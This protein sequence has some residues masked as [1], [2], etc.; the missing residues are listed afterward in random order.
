MPDN[1]FLQIMLT[2]IRFRRIHGHEWCP[3]N[4]CCAAS[5]Y[6]LKPSVQR[7]HSKLVSTLKP[8]LHRA[9][10][11]VP[12]LCDHKNGLVAGTQKVLILCNCCSTTLVPYLNDQIYC[13]GT[14]GRAKKA[15]CRQSHCHGGSSVAVVA[16]W[17]HS[18]RSMDAIGRPKE[19]QW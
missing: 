2:L 9:A 16:E 1:S 13:S 10:T 3:G 5:I 14:T 4:A 11:F 17:R 12:S 19:A 8:P 6:T 18:D 7:T 15:E